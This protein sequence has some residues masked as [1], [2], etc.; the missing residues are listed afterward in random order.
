M[1]CV[2]P[3][4]ARSVGKTYTCL[5]VLKGILYKFLFLNEFFLLALILLY[6]IIVLQK[7][8][9]FLT[10]REN[11]MSKIFTA[12]LFSLISFQASASETFTLGSC[13]FTNGYGPGGFNIA[14]C[15]FASTATDSVSF[16]NF[17]NLTIDPSY[18]GPYDVL[19]DLHTAD[20]WINIFSSG[21]YSVDTQ[22][23]DILPSTINFSSLMA[24]QLRLGSTE[25][26]F[27]NYHFGSGA[28]TFTVNDA[29]AAVP[30]PTSIALL[31]LGLV[32]LGFSARR[33]A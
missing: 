24:D 28:E 10:I 6:A 26:V 4:A 23:K 9:D 22:L 2:L 12:L 5:S 21:D 30:E 7:Q 16:S 14:T 8:S 17:T 15:N 32:G 29:A 19:V 27:Y 31:G 11:V 33:K 1:C 3:V 13:A 18:H 20:G 25:E